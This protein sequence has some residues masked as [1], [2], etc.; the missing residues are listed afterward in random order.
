MGYLYWLLFTIWLPAFVLWLLVKKPR[1]H[2]VKLAAR[3]SFVVLITQLPVEYLTLR[4]PMV[5]GEGHY[6]GIRLLNFPIEDFLFFLTFPMLVFALVH[7]VDDY[8][9]SKC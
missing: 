6:L 8:L 4:Y 1:A 7:I 9:P 2:K 5:M 3:L